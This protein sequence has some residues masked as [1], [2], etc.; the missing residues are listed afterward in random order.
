L[1]NLVTLRLDESRAHDP[2]IL[3]LIDRLGYKKIIMDFGMPRAGTSLASITAAP[4]PSRLSITDAKEAWMHFWSARW[5]LMELFEHLNSRSVAMVLPERSQA[6]L[7][8]LGFWLQRCVIEMATNS[9][10]NN[11]QDTEWSL[12]LVFNIHRLPLDEHGQ[13][14]VLEGLNMVEQPFLQSYLWPLIAK[15]TVITPP[16]MAQFGVGEGLVQRTSYWGVIEIKGD[17]RN[18]MTLVSNMHLHKT[19]NSIS[20]KDVLNWGSMKVDITHEE[21]QIKT[22]NPMEYPIIPTWRY[23]TLG[24]PVLQMMRDVDDMPQALETGFRLSLDFDAVHIPDVNALLKKVQLPPGVQVNPQHRRSYGNCGYDR[25]QAWDVTV[26]VASADEATTLAWETWK[27]FAHLQPVMGFLNMINWDRGHQFML[28]FTKVRVLQHPLLSSKLSWI[29]LV[30]PGRAM[31]VTQPKTYTKEALDDFVS[32]VKEV[33]SMEKK[34]VNEGGL[35]INKVVLS[36]KLASKEDIKEVADNDG[37]TY[38][39]RYKENSQIRGHHEA[40]SKSISIET[41]VE[42]LCECFN[43]H[44]TSQKDFLLKEVL[45]KVLKPFMVKKAVTEGVLAEEQEDAL[46]FMACGSAKTSFKIICTSETLAHW[47]CCTVKDQSMQQEDSIATVSFRS[48]YHQPMQQDWAQHIKKL[49]ITDI[50]HSLPINQFDQEAQC[51][52]DRHNQAVQPEEAPP[53]G[54]Q[55]AGSQAAG[56]IGAS[57]VESL[58]SLHKS[59][60]SQSGGHQDSASCAAS[61][62]SW[63]KTTNH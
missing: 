51:A 53:S 63:E 45:E 41:H 60:G 62:D 9:Y 2:F 59:P 48:P 57:W 7:K 5:N 30:A 40:S 43:F 26:Q 3:Q 19:I 18:L 47:L 35:L 20:Q 36:K 46:K 17:N 4:P 38:Y 39:D 58:H 10:F 44:Y 22:K 61:H 15:I 21:F 34:K 31:V 25:L 11:W 52:D 56:S 13:E 32:L 24:F 54:S 1:D 23:L 55:A 50:T 29:L 49:M 37:R 8:L 14:Q 27:L 16:K 28:E 42:V 33:N 6:N 12:G